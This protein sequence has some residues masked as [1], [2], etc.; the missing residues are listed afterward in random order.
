MVLSRLCCSYRIW[1][2]ITKVKCHSHYMTPRVMLSTQLISVYHLAG[3]SI[4]PSLPPPF[5]PVLSTQRIFKEPGAVHHLL[6]GKLHR[7]PG[8]FLHRLAFSLPHLFHHLCIS[9]WTQ[10]YLFYTLGYKPTLFSCFNYS[11][12]GHRKLFKT[13]PVS[14]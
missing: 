4:C 8:T 14:F 13:A 3:A 1:G 6:E 2:K 7:L 10:E 12:S 9:V 11:S 5:H